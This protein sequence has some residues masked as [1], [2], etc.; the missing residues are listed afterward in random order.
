MNPTHFR[1]GSP[2]RL[3]VALAFFLIAVRARAQFAI[4]WHT[5]D[6]GS[7]ISTG[8]VYAVNGTIGQPD[9]GKM[10]GGNFTL[11]GGFWSIFA[12]QTPGAPLL[13]IERQVN[14]VRVY[15]PK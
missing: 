1:R 9:A 15:W 14:A 12:V 10:T 13:S 3:L 8:G 2:V 5:I 7:G 4:D 6:G 11:E